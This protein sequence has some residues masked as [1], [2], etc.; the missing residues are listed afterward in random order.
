MQNLY[1]I[2]SFQRYQLVSACFLSLLYKEIQDEIKLFMNLG[3]VKLL[4]SFLL[5]NSNVFLQYNMFRLS[6]RL[7]IRICVPLAL[8]IGTIG[9]SKI[10]QSKQPSPASFIIRCAYSRYFSFPL[11]FSSFPLKSSLVSVPPFFKYTLA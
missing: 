10:L 6:P 8:S 1:L 11:S 2:P 5:T 3:R 7:S 4:W 9:F